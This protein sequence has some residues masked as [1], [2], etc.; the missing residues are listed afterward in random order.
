[1]EVSIIL[2]NSENISNVAGLFD[3]YRQFYGQPSDIAAATQFITARLEQAESTIFLAFTEDGKAAG[4]AQLYP[5]FTSV[6]MR[7]IWILNDLFVLPD[8]RGFGVAKALL[9]EVQSFASHT[10]AAMVKLATGV[11]N[12]VA[13]R[14]YVSMG[15]TKITQ[16]DHYTLKC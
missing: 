4:F 11:D 15:Y 12:P 2:A 1:M 5:S 7:A 10:Q 8:L 16:F 6:G 13:Q 9:N 14:L 3:E